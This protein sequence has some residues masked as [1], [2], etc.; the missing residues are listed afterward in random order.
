MKL[1]SKEKLSQLKGW[2]LTSGIQDEAG[3]FYA[4]RSLKKQSY[5]YLYPEITGYGITLLCFLYEMSRDRLLLEKAERAARWIRDVA[6]HP[7]GGVRTRLYIIDEVEHYS[8]QRGNIYTFDCAM[9]AFGL[10]KLYRL[11]KDK[12]H[13]ETAERIIKFMLVNMVK[14]NG[15]LFPAFDA[16]T[17]APYETY[18]K[19]STQSGSF[20]AKCAL[21]LC[22]MADI[23]KKS[24][25]SAAA[26]S[27]ID[28]ACKNFLDGH[29]F[30]TNAADKSSHFHPYCYS[31]EGILYLN[32]K[33]KID[34]YQTM[35]NNAFEWMVSFQAEEGGF[36]TSVFGPDQ[37]KIVHERTD[38]QAQVL[39]L[40]HL[41]TGSDTQKE[42]DRARLC[43]RL[44][45]NQD[46]ESGGFFFG[47][48]C[49]GEYKNDINAW[50]SMF[51]YQALLLAEGNV[52]RECCLDYLI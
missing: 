22:E 25:Y 35:I 6:Q 31:L 51:A 38:I 12:V 13:L 49:D 20:H 15:L 28:A 40:W 2:L 46:T 30:I 39:R 36:P 47:T 11:T 41:I 9:V 52:G 33:L 32:H 8:F 24:E 21:A 7:C 14:K 34:V 48:D 42:L 5:S 17:Q 37:I 10:L 18:E 45:E 44:L 43:G 50:C 23:Q 29:Q 3:G 1:E 4:W 19:W 26:R 27:L 16:R